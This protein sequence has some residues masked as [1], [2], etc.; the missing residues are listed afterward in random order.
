[1][2]STEHLVV[3]GA[4]YAGVQ[5][6]ISAREHG[7]AGNITV[8]GDEPHLPYQRPPLSKG[9][10]AG[11][12][13]L[14]QLSLRAPDFYKERDITLKT[15][16]RVAELDRSRQIAID[17]H[18]NHHSYSALVLATG[19]RCRVLSCAGNGLEDA[20]CL[21]DLAHSEKVRERLLTKRRILIV[22]GGFI[23]LEVAATARQLGCE[24]TVVEAR[25][26]LLERAA[27]PMLSDHLR[28]LHVHR[29]VDF[30]FDS[31]V[32]RVDRISPDCVNVEL[33]S[34]SAVCAE[35]LLVG[36]GVIPRVELAQAAGLAA[37]N[38]IFVDSACRTADPAI[39][40]VGDCAAQPNRWDNGGASHLRLESVQNAIDMGKV[41]GARIAG[42]QLSH[43][44]VPWFWSD[45]YDSKFQMVGLSRPDDEAIVRGR[46]ESG[47]FS[48]LYLRDGRLVAADSI[49][50]PLDHMALRRLI[51]GNCPASKDDLLDTER[52][53]KTLERPPAPVLG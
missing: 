38:G 53:L 21:H 2:H 11:T 23:G 42:K 46:I 30:H 19:A 6:A 48:I 35:V 41:A 14:D 50:S 15:G 5:A 52:A 34:G 4:S 36:I 22:G 32:R 29:G 12:T 1:M 18:G 8:F 33:S 10:L 51:A 25:P 27:H 43:D 20:H 17:D 49:N 3:V 13:S 31:Q 28:R 24:V 37:D 45:Q 16:V 44:A 40:A 39:Y 7:F 9:F 47:K 26:R